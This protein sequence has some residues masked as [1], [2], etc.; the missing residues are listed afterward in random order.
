MYRLLVPTSWGGLKMVAKRKTPAAVGNRTSIVHRWPEQ[1]CFPCIFISECCVHHPIVTDA[2]L[3]HWRFFW[4]PPSWGSGLVVLPAGERARSIV[5]LLLEEGM[6]CV[7]DRRH[8]G[9]DAVVV[10]AIHCDSHH[11]SKYNID[12]SQYPKHVPLCVV[13]ASVQCRGFN[14]LHAAGHGA[15]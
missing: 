15:L 2:V 12:S 4:L 5:P 1:S 7:P 13:E 9:Q 6:P 3:W 10:Y 11:T 14:S 8:Q